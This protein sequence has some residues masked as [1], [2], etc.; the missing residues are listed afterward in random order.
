MWLMGKKPWIV[1]IPGTRKME[2]MIENGGAA[3]V[4]L[5]E[6][7]IAEIDRALDDLGCTGMA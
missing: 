1:P 2:R 3:E 6:G 7:E 5:T 4:H